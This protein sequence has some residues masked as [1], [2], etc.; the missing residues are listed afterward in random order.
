[1]QLF[2]RADRT[3]CVEVADGAT[4]ADLL[5]LLEHRVGVWVLCVRALPFLAPKQSHGTQP[6]V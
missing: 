1:M 5:E 6:Q 3:H 4:A 2:V